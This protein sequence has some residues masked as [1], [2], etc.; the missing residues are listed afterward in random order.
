MLPLA[1]PTSQPPVK[2]KA[3]SNLKR[4][5]LLK[6]FQIESLLEIT[7]AINDNYSSESLFRIFEFTM[8]A[9]MGVDTLVVYHKD[10][11]WRCVC[12]YGIDG[13]SVGEIDAETHLLPFTNT[14]YVEDIPADMPSDVLKPFELIIP[15]IHKSKPL[16]YM[17]MGNIREF[18]TDSLSEKVKFIQTVSNIIVVAIEN[19]RLFRR[20]L[21]QERI[22]KELEVAGRVQNMLVPKSLPDNAVLQM[23]AFYQP[24]H[25]IGGDYYD[26]IPLNDKEFIICMADI[27][28]KGIAA[29][30]LMANVQA[31]LRALARETSNLKELVTKLNDR[32]LEITQG[33]KFIT[34]FI[35]HHN[36]ATRKFTYINA[37]HNPPIMLRDGELTWLNRGCTILGILDK[38]PFL[39][40][41]TLDLPAN[42]FVMTYTDGVTDT[43]NSKG[44]YFEVERLLEVVKTNSH[45]PVNAVNKH[46]IKAINKFKGSGVYTDD[47]SVL[48][49]R[50]F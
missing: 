35:A 23:D 16:A 15:I 32:V 39:H 12:C 24:H 7:N 22:K 36:L 33:D 30:L 9:Q 6:Q 13:K 38:L 17:L 21:E 44:E 18:N 11:A 47:I 5:L 43:E 26:Y 34:M 48:T 31:T 49:Y 14:I 4:L 10:T 42:T 46:L 28:G 41:T 3:L 20:Q 8:R 2:D 25:N 40:Q 1:I 19:K 50:V 37:G 27:S 29:A 45:L